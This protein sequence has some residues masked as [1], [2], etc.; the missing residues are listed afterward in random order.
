MK[1]SNR[2]SALAACVFLLLAALST[3]AHAQIAT[4]DKGHQIFVNNGLQI[5]GLDTSDDYSL[6]YN[7]L[8]AGNM[9]AVMWTT[10]QAQPGN[11]SA[12]QKWGT[13][14]DDKLAPSALLNADGVAHQ[15]DLIAIQVGDE[16]QSDIE[17]PNGYTQAWFAAAHAGNNF[18][19][20]LLYTNS[21]F[22]ANQTNYTNYIANANPDA[23]SWDSYP[24]ANPNGYYIAPTNWL[25]LGNIFRRNALG[26]YI[27]AT[28][29]APRPYGMYVQTYHDD[30][31]V[32][33][34][35]AEI[36]WQQFAAWT[37]GYSYVDA[38][39]YTGGNN[40]FGGQPNGQVYQSF[41]ETARQ[42]RNLGPAL[43]KLIS[44]GYGPNFI[45]GAGS[46]G[47]PGEWLNFDRNNAQPAQRYLTGIN[48]ITNLGTKNGGLS[49]DV[50]VGFFNPLL[51]NFGDPTNTTYFMVM[52]GLGGN[53]TLP[54]GQSD[55][56]A[57]VADT[58][59]Q[60]TLNFDFGIT[61]INS[62]LRL[63]RNTGQ[64]DVIN[65]GFSDGGDTVLASQGGGKYQLQLKLDGGTGDLFKYND[66]TPFV[67]VQSTVPLA[68]WDNDG[69]AANNNAATGAGLGGSGAWDSGGPKWYDGT[70]NG[71]YAAGSNVVFA[72]TAGTVTFTAPQSVTSLE[73]QTTGYT[74]S[75]S[76]LT[77]SA[78]TIS[79]DAGVTA[80][81]NATI[82]GTSGLIKNGSGTLNLLSANTYT[83]NTTINEGVLGISNASLGA[84]PGVASP[85]IQI[86]NGA[87]LRFN[88]NNLAL[89]ANRQMVM[90]AG[91][92]V[93]DTAGNNASIA[94]A[95]TGVTLTKTGAGT[96]TLSGPNTYSNTVINAG[97]LTVSADSNLGAA[98]ATFTTGNITLDGGTL[99]FG[100][101]FNIGNTRGIA[102]NAGGGTIDTQGFSNAAG[103]NA[104]NG[105]FTGPGNLTKVGPGTFFAAAP[106]GGLN[107]T[108]SGNLIIKEGTWKIVATDGLPYNVPNQDGLKAEQITLDGGT[109]QIGATINATSARRGV[110]ITSNGGTIDTQGF[111]LT[112]A[113]PFA[114]SSTSAVLTKIGTG[115]LQLNST[116]VYGPSPYAGT[117]N[118]TNGTLQLDGGTAM[119]DLAAVNLADASGV[120]LITSGATETIGSLGGG[121]Y[122]VGN[123]TLNTSL[124]TG[125]NNNSTTLYGGVSGPGGL[126]KMGAG[127]FTLAAVGGGTYGGGTTINGGKLLVDNIAGT[128]TGTGAVA[129]NSNST[130]GGSGVISGAVAV[131]SGGHIAPG[132]GLGT[133]RVG[134]LTLATGSNFDVELDTIAGV[135]KSDLLNVTNS[136]GLTINGGTLNIA[137]LGTISPGTYTL[138]DYAGALGGSVSNIALGSVPVGFTF[139]LTNN[140][141]NTSIDLTVAAEVPEPAAFS[142]ITIS[143]AI[144]LVRAW[145]LR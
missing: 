55:N 74:L 105:G 127:T 95:I 18:P 70:N 79:T 44:Y 112:W 110:T 94:G 43:T 116:P 78:P 73:F 143:V 37:M 133:F 51:R 130:L 122:T 39:I 137:N 27:G 31:A 81:I 136:N 24:F 132:D 13:W 17:D 97:T 92:G 93:I 16:Q 8:Q 60:M 99:Q 48:N 61:G 66:G 6:D 65:T 36:R 124:I 21:F 100:G 75:G 71:A 104:T 106:S 90:G 102:L 2:N 126:T 20:T 68:Y 26:S 41:Q 67:G 53:L 142:L 9:T 131:N 111:N 115:K 103:Y 25:A 101:N 125:G 85:N 30:N 14:A 54:N 50:Y 32:D 89:A 72:G 87:T 49:G 52:N 134:T 76:M 77:L 38:F 138:I 40:N 19:N 22:I 4:L 108:W 46:S 119:G 91:G 15:N 28:G 123:V 83:G 45:A 47:L 139:N 144:A 59:Q 113:G 33:P 57:T 86:N 10:G 58:R 98:P 84:L 5:W 82:A 80:T 34:G 145:R 117:V 3:P 42:G 109:W 140:A 128:G 69:S 129:V 56:T 88:A 62:L 12:G 135:G 63:N 35:E 7:E 107:T 118:V 29:N 114:G 120:N 96:L 121:G 64:V 141:A 23:I 11:L 1:N